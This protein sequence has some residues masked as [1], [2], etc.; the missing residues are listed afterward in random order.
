MDD[1][2]IGSAPCPDVYKPV[3]LI[4]FTIDRPDLARRP[5]CNLDAGQTLGRF[6]SVVSCVIAQTVCSSACR[7]AGISQA[8]TDL[9]V[10][11][12]LVFNSIPGTGQVFIHK[13]ERAIL[14]FIEGP[15]EVFTN[16]ANTDQLNTTQKQ[17][18]YHQ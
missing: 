13:I 7:N 4:I 8:G 11:A 3:T 2:V 1:Y 10:A 17:D 6:C 18:D 5:L 9:R 15:A 12:G 14:A 16:N